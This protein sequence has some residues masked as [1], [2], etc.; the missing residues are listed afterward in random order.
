M[1]FVHFVD[2]T[3]VFASDSG[4]N[5]IHATVNMAMVGVDIWFK[6]YSLSLSV[7]KTSYNDKLTMSQKKNAVDITIRDSFLP[8]VSTAKFLGV[9][10]DENLPFKDHV[11]KVTTEISKS[12]GVMK[13]LH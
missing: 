5:N 9:T 2:Y 4:F 3:T 8:K 6:A 10:L 13:R 11:N 12:V 1:R 7:S